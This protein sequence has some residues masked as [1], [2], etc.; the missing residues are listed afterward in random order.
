MPFVEITPLRS[1]DGTGVKLTNGPRMGVIVSITGE[2]LVALG[3]NDV[4]PV[5]VMLDLDPAFPRIRIVRSADGKF[6]FTRAA[7]AKDNDIRHVRIGRRP[8]M[9]GEMAG[10]ACVWELVE[11]EAGIDIDIPRE[12]MKAAVQPQPQANGAAKPV[13]RGAPYLSVNGR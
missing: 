11:G 7:L 4:R 9:K 3:V 1:K 5:R 2:A 8:E 13:A 12:L 6:G 10:V